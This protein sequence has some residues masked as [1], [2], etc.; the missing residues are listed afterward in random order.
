MT[1]VPETL[2]DELKQVQRSG[3]LIILMNSIFDY[4]YIDDFD[5]EQIY[6]I[7]GRYRVV[8]GQ[9]EVIEGIQCCHVKFIR[10]SVKK[11]VASISFE[12]V[13]CQH[14]KDEEKLKRS[15]DRSKP[16]AVLTKIEPSS[17][18]YRKGIRWTQSIEI[19]GKLRYVSYMVAML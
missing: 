12:G 5:F 3:K 14:L 13:P 18:M 2:K 6:Q 15:L 7:E 19:R 9:Q 4:D 17:H 11:N 1:N 10:G 8:S 16:V